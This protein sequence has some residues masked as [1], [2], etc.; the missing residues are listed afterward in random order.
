MKL[1]AQRIEEL[2]YLALDVIIETEHFHP[3]VWRDHLED[4]TVTLEEVYWM[5]NNLEFDVEVKYE[6]DGSP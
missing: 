6:G 5:R 2:I 1:S 4:G 3:I